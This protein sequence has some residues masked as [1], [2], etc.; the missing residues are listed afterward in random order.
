MMEQKNKKI[1]EIP[2]GI[3]AKL[4]KD[5]LILKKD[6]A[7][8]SRRFPFRRIK[9]EL[10]NGK[11]LIGSDSN[12]KKDK[13]IKG[14]VNAHIKNMVKGLEEGHVYKLKICSGHFPMNV[15]V[16]K[17][18]FIVKNFLGEKV[19]RKLK[20]KDN[21]EVKM[22]GDIVEVKGNEKELVGQT[23]ADIESLCRITNRDRRVFQDGIWI[24][25]KDGK[26]I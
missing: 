5:K 4:D 13:K 21:V 25:E 3:E 2:Q 8:I 7:S 22:E 1:I 23:A 18:E 10:E 24:T 19:P 16:S 20:I 17:N 15:D 12:T 9:I 14:T 11:L 6:N 26:K